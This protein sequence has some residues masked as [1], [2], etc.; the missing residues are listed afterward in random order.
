MSLS[1]YESS[2]AHLCDELKVLDLLIR[3]RLLRQTWNRQPNAWDQFKGLVLT[4][5]EITQLLTNAI[6]RDDPQHSQCQSLL[7]ELEQARSDVEERRAASLLTGTYLSL[8]YLSHLFQL[9][10]FQE[11]CLLICLAPEVDRKYEKLYAY[12]QDDVTRKKPSVDLVMSLLLTTP[13]QT[14]VARSAFGPQ[15]PLRRFRLIQMIGGSEETPLLSRF[16]KLDDRIAGFLLETDGLDTRL[17]RDAIFSW[18][19]VT[20]DEVSVADETRDRMRAFVS[21]AFGDSEKVI[22]Y[23]AGPDH[24]AKESLMEAI[25]LLFSRNSITSPTLS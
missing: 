13:E 15:A 4:E 24:A 18:P 1:A 2:W 17:N 6:P 10:R 5:D 23:F 8:A 9:S 22:F 16:L 11:Q 12:L 3:L 20:W 7:A 21:N 19:Q 14:I 25:F